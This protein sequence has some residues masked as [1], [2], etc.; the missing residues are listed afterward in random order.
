CPREGLRKNGHTKTIP[1]LETS[2]SIDDEFIKVENKMQFKKTEIKTK[3]ETTKTTACMN[4]TCC[5]F[6]YSNE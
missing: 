1:P 6:L 4:L 3:T 2:V 5:F